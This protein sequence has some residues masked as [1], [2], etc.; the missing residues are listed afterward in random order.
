[1]LTALVRHL[2]AHEPTALAG[3][4]GLALG[5]FLFEWGLRARQ[6]ARRLEQRGD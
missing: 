4:A 5:C 1:V 3:F 6:K 2:L